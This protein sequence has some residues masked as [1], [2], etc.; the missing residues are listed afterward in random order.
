MLRN[1]T[2]KTKPFFH[3]ADSFTN[4]QGIDLLLSD[5][6]QG[7]EGL[8]KQVLQ[9]MASLM[10]QDDLVC[11]KLMKLKVVSNILLKFGHHQE[12]IIGILDAV[13]KCKHRKTLLEKSEVFKEEKKRL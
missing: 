3:L 13:S 10:S 11:V 2:E 1:I 9:T 12:Q 6:N 7:E 5:L 8:E 4:S